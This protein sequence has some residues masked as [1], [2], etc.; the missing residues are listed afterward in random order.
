MNTK[1]SKNDTESCPIMMKF[2]MGV[3]LSVDYSCLKNCDDALNTLA[4]IL[5]YILLVLVKL[6]G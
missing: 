3:V 1:I 6:D 4:E 2:G 5:I